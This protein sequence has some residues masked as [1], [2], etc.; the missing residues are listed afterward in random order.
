MGEG[1]KTNKKLGNYGEEEATKYLADK[2]YIILFRNYRFRNGE[3]DIVAKKEGI[4]VFVEVKTRMSRTKGGPLEAINTEKQRRIIHGARYFLM[5][6]KFL[7]ETKEG[8]WDACINCDSHKTYKSIRFDA[9]Q[10]MPRE[11]HPILH[12]KN[13]FMEE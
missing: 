4:L 1:M 6:E 13:A 3:L 2:G 7:E 12:I 8:G 10:V 11:K 9:I 5:K